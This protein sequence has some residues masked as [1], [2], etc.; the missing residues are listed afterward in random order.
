M[1]APAGAVSRPTLERV[2]RAGATRGRT[3]ALSRKVWP[4]P[5]RRKREGAQEAQRIALAGSAPPEG[6]DRWT[7][8]WLA[9]QLVECKVVDTMARD[10]VRVARTKTNASHG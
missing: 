10:P 5:A 9:A 6:A 7:L 1:M 8:A 3:A 2:R 4:G